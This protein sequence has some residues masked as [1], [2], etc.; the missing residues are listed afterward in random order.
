MRVLN[1]LIIFIAGQTHHAISP[2]KVSTWTTGAAIYCRAHK[3]RL[4]FLT[5]LTSGVIVAL[6]TKIGLVNTGAVAVFV[7]FALRG[8]VVSNKAK[9]TLANSWGHAC[10]INTALC[11]NRLTL[12]RNTVKYVTLLACAVVALR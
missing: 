4:A 1:G 2:A 12:T 6:Q 5:V 3:Q 10:P 7:A 11:T 8:T 9:V